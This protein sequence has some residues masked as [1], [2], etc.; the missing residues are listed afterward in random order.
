[1]ST[2]MQQIG[3]LAFRVEGDN[4]NA[5]Y[6]LPNTMDDALYLGTLRMGVASHPDRKAAFMDLMRDAVADIIEEKTGHRPEWNKPRS[7]PEHE[8]AGRS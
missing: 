7:A 8:K 5:Y 1:M 6:A 3:R 4:W 2:D